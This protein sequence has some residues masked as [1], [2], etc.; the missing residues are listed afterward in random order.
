[1][2]LR[3]LKIFVEVVDCGS[4]TAA[5][6]KLY[7]AQPTISQA[8]SELEEHYR[9]R[10][11]ER[12][13][14]RLFITPTGQ[15]LLEYARHLLAM[16]EEMELGLNQAAQGG[17]LM[18]IG[19]SITVGASILPELLHSFRQIMQDQREGQDG[20][21]A[22]LG[23]PESPC[24]RIEAVVKNTRELEELL[25]VNQLDFALI[26][27]ALHQVELTSQ[28]FQA[29]RLGL[30]CG[31]GHPFYGRKALKLHEL[32]REDYITREQGSGTRELFVSSMELRGIPFGLIWEG[33]DFTGI[34]RAAQSGLGVAVVPLV[35]V[36]EQLS[37]GSLQLCK[38]PGLILERNFSL[39]YHRNKYVTPAM[40]AFFT[41]LFKRYNQ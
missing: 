31:R 5:A 2:N 30:V 10:L 14:R 7:I 1:M 8:I 40:E 13:S 6:D 19:A 12:Y 28:S 3:L 9:V 26:E 41:H 24:P 17:G 32:A 21:R 15:R 4:M 23:K 18:R 29:D 20:S 38:V 16:I 27:G 33:N 34:I 25:L 37:A 22:S 39:V 11:F 35:L 36:K